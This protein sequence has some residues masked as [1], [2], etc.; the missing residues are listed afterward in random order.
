MALLITPSLLDAIDWFNIAPES[1]KERAYNGLKDTLNRVWNSN[2]AVERGMAFERLVCGNLSLSR[3]AFLKTFEQ[4]PAGEKLGLF[5]DRCVGGSLQKTIKKI[6][7]VGGEEYL[8]YGKIDVSFPARNV[9]IKTTANYKG[10]NSYL[11]KTQG[12]IYAIADNKPDFEF[13]VAEIPYTPSEEAEIAK[14]TPVKVDLTKILCTDVHHIETTYN[15]GVAREEI[16]N[17]IARAIEFMKADG[18]L[19]G[20]LYYAYMHKFNMYGG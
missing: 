14:D 4:H 8:L 18:E 7:E 3:S 6:V 19:P 15:I 13:I 16:E 17:K 5:Y 20:S 1:W 9:D 2:F 11:D 12:K 10:K